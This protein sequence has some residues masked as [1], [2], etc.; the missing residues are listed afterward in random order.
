MNKRIALII[1]VLT[2][3]F[4]AS[5]EY[6][7]AE[8]C[9]LD[10]SLVLDTSGS[11]GSSWDG[12]TRIDVLK[13]S[14]KSFIDAQPEDGTR[15]VGIVSFSSTA[16]VVHNLIKIDDSGDKTSLKNAID[17]LSA[18]G[19]TAMDAGIQTGATMLIPGSGRADCYKVMIVVSDGY[20][21]DDVA[22][23]NA[24]N[25]AKAQ[26]IVII[27]VFIGSPSG[28]GD[29]FLRDEIA[30]HP[31]YPYFINVT[32]PNDLPTAF[33]DLANKICILAKPKK[34]VGG[35]II[36]LSKFELIVPWIVSAAVIV[37]TIAFAKKYIFKF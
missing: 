20:P 23:E 22:A 15:W 2:L 27:G 19:S 3:L 25:A 37:A 4:F 17:A 11:M 12:S 33:E 28:D 29:E 21:D 18:S 6:A 16:T 8:E 1:I 30:Q 13:D 7:T 9:L 26:G 35:G 36:P 31:Y 5:L 14:V 34:P 24:A 10:I 32:D